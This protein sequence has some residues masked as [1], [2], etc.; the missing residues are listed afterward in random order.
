MQLLYSSKLTWIY[1]RTADF[2]LCSKLP[3]VW[4]LMRSFD[5]H[6]L[7][8]DEDLWLDSIISSNNFEFKEG[9]EKIS[10]YGRFKH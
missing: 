7:A 5:D 10:R 6:L 3:T 4:S 2:A 9:I 1:L 8:Y